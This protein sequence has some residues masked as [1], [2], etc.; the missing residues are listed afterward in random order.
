[1]EVTALSPCISAPCILL[2]VIFFRLLVFKSG[3]ILPAFSHNETWFY[4]GFLSP[5]VIQG[6]PSKVL[7]GLHSVITVT[8][9]SVL[10][11]QFFCSAPTLQQHSWGTHKHLWRRFFADPKRSALFWTFLLNV[12]TKQNEGEPERKQAAHTAKPL[13]SRNDS[14]IFRL[15]TNT[16]T[17]ISLPHYA[18]ITLISAG[19]I[20]SRWSIMKAAG[21]SQLLC[22][23]HRAALPLRSALLR[24]KSVQKKRV[25]KIR[26]GGGSFLAWN[27]TFAAKFQPEAISYS[28]VIKLWE[29]KEVGR[30]RRGRERGIYNGK[31]GMTFASATLAGDAGVFQRQKGLALNQKD[32]TPFNSNKK[33][34][35]DLFFLSFFP[36]YFSLFHFHGHLSELFKSTC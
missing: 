30:E 36:F 35:W 5:L 18:E 19:K 2:I 6:T 22:R 29:E 1:M 8:M 10:L 34:S 21:A 32:E 27:Q 16:Y 4:S 7:P 25:L 9:V 20:K 3:V 31:A 11:F 23:S 24:L 28:W 33:I 12:N 17:K 13:S 15:N 14:A 26:R